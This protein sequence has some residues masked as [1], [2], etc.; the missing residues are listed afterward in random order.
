MNLTNGLPAW[1]LRAGVLCAVVLILILLASQGAG[2][3]PLGIIALFGL[4]SAAAPSTPAPAF[5]I[6]ATAVTAVLITDDALNI[7]VLA[8]IP[9]THLVHI[10]CALAAVIPS[11]ARIHVVALRPAAIRF[12]VVQLIVFGLAAAAAFVPKTVTPAALEAAALLGATALAVLATRLI[13]KRPQ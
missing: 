1:T 11:T 13:M 4:L 6:V 8:L 5:L 2:G 9:V 12:G 3:F 7:G 10:G